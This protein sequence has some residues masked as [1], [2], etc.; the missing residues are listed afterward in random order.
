MEEIIDAV[1]YQLEESD[2]MEKLTAG[3]VLT[4]GGSLMRHLPQLVKYR[5]G[6]DVRIGKPDVQLVGNDLKEVNHPMYS[7][8]VGLLLKGF[9]N[10][11]A[12]PVLEPVAEPVAKELIPEFAEE[13]EEKQGK[14]TK[15]PKKLGGL[16]ESFKNTI[17]GFFDD[18]TDRKM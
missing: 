11:L 7:T 12:E 8:S 2:C 14:E 5:T 9:E 18:G 15:P 4:G 1:I 10:A 17:D 16:F 13:K 3:I 6:L